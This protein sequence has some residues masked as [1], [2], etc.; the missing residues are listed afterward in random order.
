MTTRRTILSA[1]ILLGLGTALGAPAVAEQYFCTPLEVAVLQNRA[2]VL[3]ASPVGLRCGYPQDPPGSGQYIRYF[4]VPLGSTAAEK[5]WSN[6]FI[7]MGKLAQ[8]S[9]LTL[10]FQYTSGDLSGEAFGCARGDCRNPWSFAVIKVPPP[11]PAEDCGHPDLLGALINSPA[12]LVDIPPDTGLSTHWSDLGLGGV[13]ALARDI[14]DVYV[15]T[16]DGDDSLY[17]FPVSADNPTPER[18]G[19]FTNGASN[20]Q[21][22][23][24]AP[25]SVAGFTAGTL[26]GISI[27]GLGNCNPNCLFS[28]DKK[29]GAATP[30]A[31]L[32]LNQGRAMSFN[33][34]TGELWVFDQGGRGVYTVDGFGHRT[35][36][37]YLQA[38]NTTAHTGVDTMFSLAHSCDGRMFGVD[39]AYGVLLEIDQATGQS[40]WVSPAMGSVSVNGQR[41]VHGLDGPPYCGP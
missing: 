36:R 5:A 25:K 10:I 28:I 14:Q 35:L 15:A 41:S 30:I 4:A 40:H 3:C 27:D 8:T 20:I 16:G 23:D 1:L 29:T 34:K 11:W 22:M 2:H 38:S 9:G 18:V 33:P 24:I 6:R 32:Q 21:A 31:G 19:A 7:Q 17:R 26:Y 12:P 39:V 13:T 37:F